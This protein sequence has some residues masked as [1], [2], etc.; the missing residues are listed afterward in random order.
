MKHPYRLGE[1]GEKMPNY[2]VNESVGIAV[3]FLLAAIHNAGLAALTYTP[4][5]M[6][7]LSE[8]L[9]RPENERPF[10]VIPVGR[11]APDAQVPDLKRKELK[12][13]AAFYE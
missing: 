6:G 11:P 5:P 2:Y 10:M 3:G 7:F 8:A 13:I 12:D 4:S 1:A 9:E